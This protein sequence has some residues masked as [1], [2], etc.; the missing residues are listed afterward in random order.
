L[1]GINNDKNVA[2][3]ARPPHLPCRIHHRPC[4][5]QFLIQRSYQY[6]ANDGYRPVVLTNNRY[7][8]NDYEGVGAQLDLYAGFAARPEQGDSWFISLDRRDSGTRLAQAKI[9]YDEQQDCYMMGT[10]ALACGIRENSD[11]PDDISY[12]Y[13]SVFFFGQCIRTEDYD[14]VLEYQLAGEPL[15]P[16]YKSPFQFR[17]TRFQPKPSSASVP[18]NLTPK[19][20]FAMGTIEIPGE[21]GEVSVAYHDDL[22]CLQRVEGAEVTVTSTVVGGSNGRLYLADG[23]RGTGKFTSLGYNA[24][25]DDTDEFKSTKIIGDTDENGIFKVLYQAQ[26]HGG[27]EIIKFEV[28]LPETEGEPGFIGE[29][30]ERDLTISI[31]GLVEMTT[32]NAPVGF[33]YTRPPENGCPHTPD[34]RWLTQNS[35]TRMAVLAELYR[36]YTG[37][38]LSLNDA[39]LPLGGMIANRK[40]DGRDARCHV[41]HRNGVDVDVNQIDISGI[42]MR[43]EMI[44][45]NEV[46]LPVLDFLTRL[47][48]SVGGARADETPIHYQF[49][50]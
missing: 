3:R 9:H 31:P 29:S 4:Q 32:T 22:G 5:S 7:K 2:R 18:D 46:S 43:S 47:A 16:S 26:D 17:P 48:S 50:H 23:E 19:Q 40:S 21:E 49:S 36:L 1:N 24:E 41:W 33:V 8:R 20:F 28:K 38:K 6:A 42:N 12:A 30:L 44:T 34:P 13:L 25:V 37:R 39:S 27:N 35:F 45:R 10:T 11:A 14:L 15:T